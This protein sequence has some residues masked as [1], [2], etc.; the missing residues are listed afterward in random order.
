MRMYDLALVAANQA[1]SGQLC[2]CSTAVSRK[3]HSAED[4]SFPTI[5]AEYNGA[6]APVNR[7]NA[8]VGYDE[9]V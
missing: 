6:L 8:G 4:M 7:H 5:G 2:D 3:I 9:N 1:S